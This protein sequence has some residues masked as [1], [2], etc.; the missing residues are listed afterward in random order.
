MKA[1]IVRLTLLSSSFA[2]SYGCGFNDVE[3]QARSM[4]LPD[5]EAAVCPLGLNRR[6]PQH[7]VLNDRVQAKGALR[8]SPRFLRAQPSIAFAP[9]EPFPRPTLGIV[10]GVSQGGRPTGRRTTGLRACTNQYTL[11]RRRHRPVALPNGSIVA[12][13][14]N[15]RRPPHYTGLWG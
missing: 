2:M 11:R 15:Y 8:S 4:L 12:S 3:A 14:P 7:R 1:S 10:A 6:G 9:T 13:T 5:A